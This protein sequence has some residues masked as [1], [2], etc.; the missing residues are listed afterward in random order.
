[1][2]PCLAINAV[3]Q[4]QDTA[5][6]LGLSFCVLLWQAPACLL[7]RVAMPRDGDC[8]FHAIAFQDRRGGKALRFEVAAFMRDEASNQGGFEAAWLHDAQSLLHGAWGGYTAICA[9]SL[10]KRVRVEIH[11]CQ[12]SGK[13]LVV[14]G[15]HAELQGDPNAPLKRLLY[16]ASDQH[17]EALVELGNGW[18]LSMG[19]PPLRTQ[20]SDAFGAAGGGGANNA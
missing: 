10:M 17:Y 11:I 2:M 7:G 14:D 16:D 3:A 15:S 19:Q 1:M 4:A 13:T 20:C 6:T 12:P 18:L 5:A 8:L 9:Y